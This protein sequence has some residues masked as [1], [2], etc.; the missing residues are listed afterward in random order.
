MKL[1]FFLSG[2]FLLTVSAA[3]CNKK[4]KESKIFSEVFKGRLE[5]KAICMNYTVSV[6]D[7]A[8]TLN[9]VPNWTD[10]TTK[11]T[12]KNVFALANPCNFPDSIKQGDEFYFVIDTLSTKPCMVC[13]AYY[14]TPGKKLPIKIVNK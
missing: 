13:M 5:I 9:V 14:P 1:L 8:D 6:L 3:N 11:K 10:E 2:I 4:D 12:Y 7:K